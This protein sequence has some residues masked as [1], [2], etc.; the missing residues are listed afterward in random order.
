MGEH[1][2]WAWKGCVEE[3]NPVNTVPLYGSCLLYGGMGSMRQRQ[4]MVHLV[5]INT[6]SKS[7]EI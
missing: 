4:G 5:A 3:T 7:D 1:C 6:A 2:R